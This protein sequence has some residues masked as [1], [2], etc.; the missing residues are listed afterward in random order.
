MR[1]LLQHALMGL[2]DTA[3]ALIPQPLPDR[4]ALE[5][6]R[7]VSHRGEHDNRQVFE[8][9]LAAF[10]AAREAGVWGIECDIRWTADL[11]PVV[12]H[13]PD[14]RRVFGDTGVL[15]ELS[16]AELRARTPL[17]PSLE[18]LVREFGGDRH[19]M[20]EIKAE[21]YPQPDHQKAIL[22]GLISALEPARDYHFLAL[23]PALFRHVDF[24]PPACLLPVAEFNVHSLS[25]ASLA[26]GYAGLAGHYL[27]LGNAL[28]RRHEARGQHI[29][30]GHI[31]SRNALFRELNRGVEWI[32]SND[33][34][35][36]QRLLDRLMESVRGRD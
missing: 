30:T 20:L 31:G 19:L 35:A 5:S 26:A 13:D 28:K 27:L 10:T 33:A 7:L 29:G 22:A 34:V 8:N 32:F 12:A 16:F 14:G 3:T 15:S 1:E 25:H 9:T 36:M 18:E 17:V 23:D 2:V 6:C 24:A 4:D 21:S 11:V